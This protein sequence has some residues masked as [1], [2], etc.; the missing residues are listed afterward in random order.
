[1][2]RVFQILS[3]FL[4]LFSALITGLGLVAWEPFWNLLQP[5]QIPQTKGSAISGVRADC[6]VV[7]NICRLFIP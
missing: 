1:M 4:L 3:G 7:F 2:P 6:R 5:F